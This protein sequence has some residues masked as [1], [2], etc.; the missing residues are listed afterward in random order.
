MRRYEGFLS[1]EARALQRLAGRYAP[2][3]IASDLDGTPPWVAEVPPHSP[4]GIPAEALATVLDRGDLEPDAALELAWHLCEAVETSHRQDLVH[5]SIDAQ[6]V[7][8]L[9]RS[10]LLT[11]W[12]WSSH[13]SERGPHAQ[14]MVA[15]A[16]LVTA[17][18]AFAPEVDLDEL[19]VLL[20]ECDPGLPGGPTAGQ[21]GEV[22]SARLGM[23]GDDGKL[24]DAMDGLT[25]AELIRTRVPSCRRIAVLGMPGSSGK[26][27][28]AAL[29]ATVFA[30]E[31]RGRTIVVDADPGRGTLGF[32]VDQNRGQGMSALIRILDRVNGPRDLA[33]YLSRMESG[34][35]VLTD[36]VG[37]PTPPSQQVRRVCDILAR[38]YEILITDSHTTEIDESKRAV[39]SQS[40]QLVL[41]TDSHS[42]L[43][44]GAHVDYFNRLLGLGY[45]ELLARSV[46]VV[47]KT[48]PVG[49]R[50]LGPYGIIERD[51]DLRHLCRGIVAIP[52]SSYLANTGEARLDQLGVALR[53]TYY[54]LAALIAQSFTR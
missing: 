25:R 16:Q 29:L 48:Q 5:G 34:A 45:K 9:G 20:E 3:L 40:D 37:L 24:V 46:I 33:P 32:R 42:H 27:T 28:T 22:L 2:Q 44:S 13:G 21:L 15:L 19:R 26:S 8:C 31:R 36:L 7:R 43:L 23:Q 4:D 18:I 6:T 50:P 41:V 47:S 11:D 53:E 49:S 12:F 54:D 1:T 52:H 10:V 14:D 17:L 38:H 51:A 30:T 35:D 39:L